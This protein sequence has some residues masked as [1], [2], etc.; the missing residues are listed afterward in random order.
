MGHLTFYVPTNLLL[1]EPV[2]MG[3]L[4]DSVP[5]AEKFKFRYHQCMHLR[6]LMKEIWKPMAVEPLVVVSWWLL[7]IYCLGSVWMAVVVLMIMA[8]A[9]SFLFI[10]FTQGSHLR[11][12]AMVNHEYNQELR[13]KRLLT[14][15]FD[16]MGFRD[17]ETTNRVHNGIVAATKALA[18]QPAASTTYAELTKL[19][20]EKHPNFDLGCWVREQI[21]YT[22]DFQTD[23]YFW[24]FISGGLN[25]Q[26]IHHCL[27]GIAHRHHHILY[28]KFRAVLQSTAYM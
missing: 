18:A 3:P 15:P 19:R 28:P 8:A 4:D 2:F 12:D 22:V 20:A 21:A 7:G 6:S 14:S 25:M 11:E 26:A 27:P 5:R 23:S 13:R 17:G 16:L 1:E 10:I 9:E 24:Y